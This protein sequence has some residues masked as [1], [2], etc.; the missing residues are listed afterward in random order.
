METCACSASSPKSAGGGY[1]VPPASAGASKA[2]SSDSGPIV[3]P[4]ASQAPASPTAAAS[5]S[6]NS[7]VKVA[8]PSETVYWVAV[9]ERFTLDRVANQPVVV[10]AIC[11]ST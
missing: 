4:R 6:A 11:D 8:I 10:N 2:V 7:H 1:S 3:V 5:A 9:G